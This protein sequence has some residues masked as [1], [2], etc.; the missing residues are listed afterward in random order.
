ML[1]LDGRVLGAGWVAALARQE[2]YSLRRWSRL[3]GRSKALAVSAALALILV[4]GLWLDAGDGEGLWVAAVLFTVL[5][6]ASG[7]MRL[8]AWI[9][10]GTA[11]AVARHRPQSEYA[12]GLALA[13]GLARIHSRWLARVSLAG[14]VVVFL[15]ALI[16][17]TTE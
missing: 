13:G 1:R 5:L 16:L 9:D 11:Q 6:L 10:K 3:S 12:Q 2:R 4:S 14:L 7:F 8:H 15:L 17:A